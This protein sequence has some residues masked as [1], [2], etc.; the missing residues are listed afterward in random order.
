[1][2]LWLRLLQVFAEHQLSKDA[3]IGNAV[4]SIVQVITV[5]QQTGAA[6]P[7]RCTRCARKL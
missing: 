2:W 7:E 4:I 3:A 1:M 6:A 5:L